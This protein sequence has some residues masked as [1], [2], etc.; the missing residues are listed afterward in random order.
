MPTTRTA[1]DLVNGDT[2]THKGKTYVVEFT[3]PYSRMGE[4]MVRVYCYG[5]QSY[6]PFPRSHKV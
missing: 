3:R 1:D 2:F 6:F 4:K 5:D